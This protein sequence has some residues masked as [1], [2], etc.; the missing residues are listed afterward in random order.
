M[1]PVKELG[2]RHGD[3]SPGTCISS[4]PVDKMGGQWSLAEYYRSSGH[5]ILTRP[6]AQ[7]TGHVILTRAAATTTTLQDHWSNKHTAQGHWSNKHTA[8]GHWSNKHTAQGH[9]SY[10]KKYTQN[11][12]YHTTKSHWVF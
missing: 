4:T 1:R 2:R 9:W 3:G 11:S 5:V 8:Q 12:I 10:K 7:G 6:R